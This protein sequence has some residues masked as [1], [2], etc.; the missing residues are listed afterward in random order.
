MLFLANMPN[1]TQVVM[2]QQTIL[3]WGDFDESYRILFEAWIAGDIE[4]TEQLVLEPLKANPPM[5][6]V[7]IKNRNTA[8]LEP[9]EDLLSQKGIHFVA[10]GTGHLVGPDS[11]IK[12]FEEKGYRVVRE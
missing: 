6:Q 5:Y 7:L 4:A 11:L 12:L 9:L 3:A 2:L 10:V 1:E 8:W